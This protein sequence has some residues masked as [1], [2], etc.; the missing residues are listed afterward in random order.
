MIRGLVV[1]VGGAAIMVAGLT[2]CSNKDKSQGTASGTAGTGSTSVQAGGANA[3]AGPGTARVSIDGKPKDIQGQVVCSAMGGNMNIA[4]GQQA[5]GIAVVMA[6]DASKVSSVGLGN[7]DGVVL[8][9]QEMASGANAS[10]TKDGKTYKVTGT[11]SG[12]DMANPMQP[13]TKPFEIEVT[14]P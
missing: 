7:V 4:I 9:Y 5:T 1:A 8:G 12:V 3:S 2:G 10:A 11:A 14:C 6:E 13:I